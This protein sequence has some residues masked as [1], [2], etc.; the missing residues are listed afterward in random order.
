[1]AFFIVPGFLPAL[2]L[3]AFKRTNLLIN[4]QVEV[5]KLVE[6]CVLLWSKF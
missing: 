2:S 6:N 4:L 1:M 3:A 5:G